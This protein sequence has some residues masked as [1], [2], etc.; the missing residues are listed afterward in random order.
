MIGKEAGFVQ[1][2][3]KKLRGKHMKETPAAEETAKETGDNNDKGIESKSVG[4][5]AGVANSVVALLVVLALVCGGVL[6]YIGGSRFSPAAR[7][8][9]DAEDTIAEYDMLFAEMYTEAFEE[10]ASTGEE[11][12][13]DA[14]TDDGAIAALSGNDVTAVASEP[15]VVAEYNGGVIMS[16][17]ATREYETVLAEYVMKGEDVSEYSDV[18]VD[19]VLKNLVGD[20]IAYEKAVEMGYTQ[21]TDEDRA[22]IAELAEAEYSDTVAF[23]MELV[24]EEGM[25]EEEAY[26]AAADY[27]ELTEDYTLDSVTAGLETDYWYERLYDSVTSQV[28]VGSDEIT[29]TYNALLAQ[30]QADF[31]ADHANFENALINGDTIVYYPQGYRAVK[32]IFFELDSEA[33]AQAAELYER[34]ENAADEA[35]IAEINSA[36]D[37]LYAPLVAQAEA[38]LAKYEDGESF[39][40]LMSD[41]SADDELINGYF[42]DTGYYVAADS[43]MWSQEFVDGAMALE[44]PGDVSAPVRTL[45]GVHIIRY[46]ANVDAGAVLL[47]DV[48]A[49]MTADTQEAA[50]M[51][52]FQEQLDAWVSEA[53]VKYYPERLEI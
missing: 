42:A 47:S 12:F 30:Q 31:D 51:T 13:E 36:L 38:V 32:Q 39:D 11:G 14:A 20:R 9:A 43:T 46:I 7:K 49:R 28:S 19:T 10:A 53:D 21:L 29:Q 24:W 4:G 15:V 37:E 44:L 35:E 34:L 17:E 23:Y 48:S 1:S 33:Q 45:S 50:E 5:K 26:S 16:D 8:L 27:L 22:K 25:N 41:Y 52:A 18:I 2:E 6:G 3:D 40:Q